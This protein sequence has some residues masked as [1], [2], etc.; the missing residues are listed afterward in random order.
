MQA[1]RDS[2]GYASTNNGVFTIQTLVSKSMSDILIRRTTSF[3]LVSCV[4]YETI[5]IM[6]TLEIL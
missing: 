5:N 1:L 6:K 3:K 2:N 4:K